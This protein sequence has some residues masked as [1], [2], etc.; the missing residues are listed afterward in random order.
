MSPRHGKLL[1]VGGGIGGLSV[2][3]A[4]GRAGVDVELLEGATEF[5]EIGYGIQLAPNALRV[6]DW[7]GVLDAVCAN[8]VFPQQGVMMSAET[9]ERL[10]AVTFGE[11]FHQRYGYPYVVTHRRDLLNSLLAACRA[12][13]SIALHNGKRVET[14]TELPDKIWVSCVDGSEFV[15]DAVVGADGI[16]SVVRDHVVGDGP[17]VCSGDV[18]YRGV[19]PID[20]VGDAAGADNVVWWVGPRMHLIQYPIRRGE[21][22]NQVAVFNSDRYR[23]GIAHDQWGTADELDSLFGDK[24][25]PVRDG[26]NLISRDQKWPLHDRNSVANWTRGRATLL[27]DAAHAMLQYLAQGACQALEDAQCLALNLNSSDDVITAFESYQKDRIA[28]TAH[29]QRW[30]RWM[31]GIVHAD[32]G[33]AAVRNAL[34]ATRAD[35]DFSYFDWLYCGSDA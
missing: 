18:A 4:L 14:I 17:P 26:V 21:L 30:A 19:A 12:T 20:I 15:A 23:P 7:L 5:G 34:L 1:V 8:G 32:G 27:G 35:N 25:Q 2:A 3:L 9:G 22:F 10:T 6:L 13:P 29:V 28:K 11:E 16:R 31:G 24:V 33:F